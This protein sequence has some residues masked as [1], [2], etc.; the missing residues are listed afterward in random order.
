MINKNF[1]A[2]HILPS[3]RAKRSNPSRKQSLKNF[4]GGAGRIFEMGCFALLAMLLPLFAYAVSTKITNIQISNTTP[5]QIMIKL[6]SPVEPHIF[7][8]AHPNRLVFDFPNTQLG[9]KLKSLAIT[10]PAIKD[11]RSGQPVPGTL[12]IVFDI[13]SS[14]HFEAAANLPS[15]QVM[16]T[17]ETSAKNIEKKP[18]S[19]SK[20]DAI[21]SNK[22]SSSAENHPL[23]VMI[24]PGHGG[25]DTGAIGKS[26]IQEKNVVLKIS[27][28]LANLIN[29]APH[30]RAVL[31]RDGDYYVT[32]HNRLVLARKNKADIYI[33]VHADSYFNN[34]AT[35]ASVYA[36]SKNGATSIAAR[37]LA[38][39]D[40]YSELG[41]VALSQLDDQSP[42]LRS[43]LIDLAQT[44][45][46]TDSMRLGTCLL[47]A[48]DD[49]AM[50]HYSR[51]EQAPFMVLKSPDIPSVLV[52]TGFIS[53]PKEESR[54][55]D[56]AYQYKL[57]V[58]LFNGIRD[59]Q[60]KYA[61]I[62]G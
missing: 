54:L 8:L 37:W 16:V 5:C 19:Q 44:V 21:I 1:I 7:T 27:K 46:V 22:V 17:L 10:N 4:F 53:N 3:L 23:I 55:N 13:T 50:L 42:L 34:W 56:K 14:F 2:D 28:Q 9:I 62:G 38:R 48:I 60:K 24:D 26:G 51:V 58:S 41:G 6:S 12:R 43:V 52:E 49:V 45:T 40:N 25:K 20:R 59:Y 57:A 32:L 33:S 47:N 18:K 61:I 35:G 11:V 29:H 36:L 31:T 30:M 39:R 15:Q